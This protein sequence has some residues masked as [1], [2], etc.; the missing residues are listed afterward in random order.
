M[1]GGA[2]LWLENYQ[3]ARSARNAVDQMVHETKD[4]RRVAVD[5]DRSQSPD[6][7]RA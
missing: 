6:V 1:S 5:V 3:N 2:P 7:D 4:E